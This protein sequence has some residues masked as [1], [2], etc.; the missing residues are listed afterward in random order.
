MPFRVTSGC[1]LTGAWALL[2]PSWAAAQTLVTVDFETPADYPLLKDK[3]NLYNTSLPS[4]QELERDAPLLGLLN[5]ESMRLEQAWGY[6][7]TL[8]NVVGGTKD[9]LTFDFSAP[10][11]WQELITAQGVLMHWSY[12]YTPKALSGSAGDVP[13]EPGWST[14][15]ERAWQH[16]RDRGEPVLLH[17]VWNEPDFPALGFF[18]GTKQDFFDLYTRTAKLLRQLD[19]DA[20]IAGPTTA[21]PFWL[22]EFVDLVRDQRLPLDALTFH[23][24]TRLGDNDHIAQAA[25]ALSRYAEL[26]TVE[27]VMDEY[28]PYNPWPNNGRQQTFEGATDLLYDALRFARRPELTSLNWAQFQEP[29]HHTDQFLGMVTVD[30]HPKATFNGLRLYGMLPVDSVAHSVSGAPLEVLASADEHRAGIV[31]LNR[32]DTEQPVSIDLAAPPFA[33]GNARIYRID[34]QHNSYLDG[35]GEHLTPSQT[36]SDQALADWSFAGPV[37]SMGTLAILF[38]DGSGFE[39]ARSVVLGDIVRVNRYYPSRTTTAYADFDRRTWVARLGMVD[40]QQADKQVGVTVEALPAALRFSTRLSGSPQPVDRN[41]LLGVRLD[42]QVA[43]EYTKGVLFHGPYRGGPQLYSQERDGRVPFG[44]QRQPDS[45]VMVPDFA[46]FVVTLADH[47]PAGANGRVQL[48]Y[49]MQ[50]TGPG[51]RAVITTTAADG[52]EPG[53]GGS[54]GVAGAPTDAGGVAGASTAGTGAAGASAGGASPGGA[55]NGGAPLSAASVTPSASSCACRLG[56]A[57]HAGQ[58]VAWVGLAWLFGARRR[59]TS[60]RSGAASSGS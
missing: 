12:N 45:V 28:H 54:A 33:R 31:V 38:D 9:D 34:A 7:Q 51:T 6:G 26:D 23:Q 52:S 35:A 25:S 8:S 53:Q 10:D 17:E 1:F 13:P 57:E 19:P 43:G 3:L 15:V 60:R 29:G 2:L 27:M 22:D 24:Y 32:T 42:F 30:G 46:K 21:F 58:S 39:P 49:V 59:L 50:N 41:T 20:K 11:R 44:T 36:Q 40:E 55:P 56:R 4:T 47:A 48:T 18:N 37:P 14:C 5:V 16:W